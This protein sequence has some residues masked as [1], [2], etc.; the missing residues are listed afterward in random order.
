M[1]R[2]L[3]F[4]SIVLLAA[5]DEDPC[6]NVICANGDAIQ[7]GYECFCL[8]DRGWF[9][10]KCD[11]EDPCQTQAINCF[12]GGTCVNGN[13]ICPVGFEGDTCEIVVR[14]FYIG[15]Y[16]TELNCPSDTTIDINLS[17]QAP[18]S[19]VDEITEIILYNIDGQASVVEGEINES[20]NVIIPD[21]VSASGTIN[22]VITRSSNGFLIELELDSGV[23]TKFCS[24]EVIK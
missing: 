23:G 13:C 5:C 4:F 18:D 21:Q 19:L 20:G 22:G 14:D 3:F 1:Y 17:I 8:C 7:D 16:N 11:Q 9:G 2:L 10:E 15:N 6:E 12:N 24:I